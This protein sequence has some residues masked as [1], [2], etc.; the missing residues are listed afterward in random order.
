MCFEYVN[1]FIVLRLNLFFKLKGMYFIY[2]IEFRVFFLLDFYLY[3][4]ELCNLILF[5]KCFIRIFKNV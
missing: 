2:M 3:V 5:L 1:M 4:I